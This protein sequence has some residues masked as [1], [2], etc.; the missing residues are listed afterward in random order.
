MS[1]I[2][3]AALGVA[4]LTLAPQLSALF[5][6]P[7]PSPP[8]LGDTNGLFLL[9]V[10]LGYVLPWRDPE[11]HRG[12]MWI[13]GPFLKGLGALVFL[14]DYALRDSPA[15]YLLFAA[16]DGSLALATLWALR[17]RAGD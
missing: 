14:R 13:M 1:G 16:T 2:Y 6:T 7:A 9:S 4:L 12:Y 17:R 5:G 10:G 3:D 11:R 15:S 8:V